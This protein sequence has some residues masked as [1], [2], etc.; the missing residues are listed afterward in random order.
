MVC[1]RIC[2]WQRMCIQNTVPVPCLYE[3]IVQ[4]ISSLISRALPCIPLP[5]LV[6]EPRVCYHH[7]VFFCKIPPIFVLCRF[8]ILDQTYQHIHPPGSLQLLRSNHLVP[9]HNHSL[10]FPVKLLPSVHTERQPLHLC[11]Q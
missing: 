9:S 2:S 11:E 6:F 8:W 10:S 7:S 1:I 5:F 3:Y 4:L